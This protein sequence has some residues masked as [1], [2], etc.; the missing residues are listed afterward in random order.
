VKRKFSEA[1]VPGMAAEVSRDEIRKVIFAMDR[2]KASGSDGF[3]AGFFQKAWPVIGVDVSEAILEFFFY[4]KLLREVNATIITLVSKR[5]S[6]SVMGDYRPISCCNLFYKCIT[7]II[8]NRLLPGLDDIIGYTQGA[9]IPGRSISENIQLAQE[10]VCNYH[11]EKGAPRCT[12]KVY[13]MKAYDSVSWEFIIHCLHCFGAPQRF[14]GW[15]RECISSPSYSIALNGSLVGYFPGQKG[16]RQGDPMSPYLFVMAM[17]ILSL[18]LEEAFANPRFG[19]HPKFHSLKLT[20]LCFADDLLIFSPAKLE[21]VQVI[22][23][24]LSSF[25]DLSGLKA[26]PAKSSVFCASLS[27]ND[28]A[29][30]LSLL[31]MSEGTLPVRY[32]GVP[33]ISKR[34]S[35]IDCDTLVAKVVNRIESCL[36]KNLS[37]AG[38]LQLITSVCSFQVFWSR[39]FILPKKTIKL[40]EQKLNRFLWCGKDTRAKAKVAWDKVCVP[41]KEGGLG[42]KKLDIWNQASMLHHVWTLFARSGSLWV[43]WIENNLLKWRSFWQVSIPQNC[44]WSW[45]KLLKLRSIA[46]QFLSF[47]VGDGRKIFL[48]YDVWH[49]EGCLFDK[50]GYRMI[51]DAGSAIGPKVSS[52]IK[53]GA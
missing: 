6:P 19:F 9:F 38:Q 27:D 13:L 36:V 2:N 11:R 17:K 1:C 52:I 16:L 5:K 24:V 53:E 8:A 21:S 51:Y 41:K 12:L 33:L 3:S 39:V 32:I 30:V 28:K 10:L 25:E 47:K 31:R 15:V 46:K 50:Y 37:F 34:L 43:A 44:S 22:Q 14:V 45:R 26:N 49:P 35:A 20:H 48:W 23:E 18:L 7:K 4:G 42:I 40:L 29:E